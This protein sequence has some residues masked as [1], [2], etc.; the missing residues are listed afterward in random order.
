M[1]MK[2]ARHNLNFGYYPVLQIYLQNQ[3]VTIEDFNQ[4]SRKSFN[5]RSFDRNYVLQYRIINT[6][7]V[8]RSRCRYFVNID[9]NS[10]SRSQQ[11]SYPLSYYIKLPVMRTCFVHRLVEEEEHFILYCK[12]M[13]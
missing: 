2:T 10:Q 11:N 12:I 4:A 3:P 8:F 6:D 13:H 9:N 5:I 1:Y 7:P